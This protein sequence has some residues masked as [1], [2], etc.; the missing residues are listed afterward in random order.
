MSCSEKSPEFDFGASPNRRLYGKRSVA[1][2]KPSGRRF[3]LHDSTLRALDREIL[4][5]QVRLEW[6]IGERERI[7][8]E[9]IKQVI[10]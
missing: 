6:L 1:L 7:A 8:R 9:R 10:G 2:G 3:S 4:E 5:A